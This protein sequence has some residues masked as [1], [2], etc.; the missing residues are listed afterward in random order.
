MS[1]KIDSKLSFVEYAKNICKKGDSKLRA[2]TKAI[3]YMETRNAFF[4]AQSNYCPLIWMFHSFYIK[5]YV[6]ICL[7]LIYNDKHLSYEEL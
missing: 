4:N 3:P 5:F 6:I 7:Q 2:L 1:V